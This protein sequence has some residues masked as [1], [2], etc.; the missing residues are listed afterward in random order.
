MGDGAVPN[1][2][3]RYENGGRNRMDAVT[4]TCE[5]E[6]KNPQNVDVQNNSTQVLPR[7]FEDFWKTQI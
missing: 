3:T 6:R 1:L 7:G 4:M 2:I 5:I